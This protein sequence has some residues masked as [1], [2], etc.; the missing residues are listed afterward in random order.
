MLATR[1]RAMLDRPVAGRKL[2]LSLQRWDGRAG[3]YSREAGRWELVTGE[4]GSFF[5]RI[6]A[7]ET[8]YYQLR[9][10]GEDGRGNPLRCVT[11]LYVFRE[12]GR[13]PS[14]R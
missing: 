12:A 8:G 13:W 3:R 10:E 6:T 11:Y 7:E 14:R 4:D 5:L 9:L 2:G 1:P